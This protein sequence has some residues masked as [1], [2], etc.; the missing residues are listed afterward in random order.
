MTESRSD[1]RSRST[2][3]HEAGHA[4]VSILQ[5]RR[6]KYA[7][8]EPGKDTLGHVRYAKARIP[9]LAGPDKS[10]QDIVC[11]LAGRA[12]ELEFGYRPRRVLWE[13]DRL[14]AIEMALSLSSGDEAEI[15]LWLKIG[16]ARARR[17]ARDRRAAIEAVA[18]ALLAR[19]TLSES[20]VWEAAG[21]HALN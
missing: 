11:S 16:L 21:G 18:E 1:R 2:A 9:G 3:I 8:I 12:A 13:A 20:E 17:M 6:I 10:L 19:G 5:R 14:N 4:V 15:S 7:T